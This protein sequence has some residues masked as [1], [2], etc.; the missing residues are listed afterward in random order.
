MRNRISKVCREGKQSILRMREGKT[1]MSVIADSLDLSVQVSGIRFKNPILVGSAGYA[2][3]E[4]G[5]RRFIKRGYAGVV[6][7]STSREPL[8]GAPA[9]RVFWYDPSIKLRLDGTE[10]HRNPGIETMTQTVRNIA[11]ESRKEDCRII[12]SLSFQSVEEAEYNA[13]KFEEAGVCAVELDG[14]CPSTGPGLGPKYSGRGIWWT[15][16]AERTIELLKALKKSLSIPI[17]YKTR[18]SPLFRIIDD[19][20]KEVR[21]DAYCFVPEKP[22]GLSIDIQTAK[23]RLP[24]GVTKLIEGGL[25]FTPFAGPAGP[26]QSTVLVTAL[27]RAKTDVPL[28]PSGGA[29]TGID[30]LEL[31]MAGANA[32][33]ICTVLYKDINVIDRMLREIREFMNLKARDSILDLYGA[34]L[35]NIPFES[36]ALEEPFSYTSF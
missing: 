16:K 24:G 9:P 27:L 12:G 34:A 2:Y 22:P 15:Q 29:S 8:R 36:F 31:V 13:K 19:V 30:I 23:P 3:D 18:A 5:I 25:K 6:T 28:I 21:P 26:F 4:R 35:K 14:L 32:V 17:W 1:S 10:A 33:Q 20:E 11:E 7:K